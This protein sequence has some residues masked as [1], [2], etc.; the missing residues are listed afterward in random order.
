MNLRIDNRAEEHVITLLRDERREIQAQF[1]EA[2]YRLGAAEARVARL[3]A[4]RHAE[5][6]VP[7]AESRYA[8]EPPPASFEESSE[9]SSWF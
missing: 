9:A 7:A 1:Q 3:E 8:M 4:P 6:D 5:S 2:S